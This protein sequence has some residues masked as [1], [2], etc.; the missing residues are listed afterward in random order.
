MSS[1][2][3][4]VSE[5]AARGLQAGAARVF[6]LR[7]GRTNLNAAGLLRGRLDPRLD[8]V[9]RAE[10][11]R[12]GAALA[13]EDVTLVVASPLRRAVETAEAV[14]ALHGLEVSVD[15]RLADRDYGRWAG[16]AKSEVE[17]QHGSLD[18]APGVE[19]LKDVTQR[20]LK[21]IEELALTSLGTTA[22][23]V[24]HDVI[25]RQVLTSLC[26]HLGDPEMLQQDTGC[27]NLL[28]FRDGCWSVET[29]NA[30]PGGESTQGTEESR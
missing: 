24:T 11:K 10:A 7:H 13:T 8:A 17:A 1:K 3:E 26:P 25:L 23:A 29:L 9:G 16:H 14:A 19:S 22:V 6:L 12:L 5:P 27:L 21:A 4:T 30:V 2:L 20:A 28:L 15:E 18:H